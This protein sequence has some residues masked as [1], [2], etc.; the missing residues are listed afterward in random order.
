VKRNCVN[1]ANGQSL[2]GSNIAADRRAL[3]AQ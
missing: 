2:A 1:P 3:I